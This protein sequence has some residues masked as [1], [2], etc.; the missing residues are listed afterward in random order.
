MLSQR[1][2]ITAKSYIIMPHKIESHWSFELWIVARCVMQG[3]QVYGLS[4]RSLVSLSSAI[5]EQERNRCLRL[6]FY[7]GS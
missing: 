6:I 5:Y 3:I 1:L 4:I 2:R 7:L